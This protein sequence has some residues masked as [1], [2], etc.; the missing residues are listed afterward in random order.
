MS[1]GNVPRD[2]NLS[3][4][5]TL[6]ST[7]AK[8]INGLFSANIRTVGDLV[9]SERSPDVWVTAPDVTVPSTQLGNSYTLPGNIE[10]TQLSS[11]FDGTTLAVGLKNIVP[12][13]SVASI[14]TNTAVFYAQVPIPIPPD[15][16]GVTYGSVSLSDSGEIFAMGS[17]NDNA[18]VGAV[19]LFALIA[20][21]WTLQG[22]KIT[23]PGEIGAGNFG[24]QVSLSGNGTLLAVGSPNET[25]AGAAYIFNVQ[26]LANPVFVARIVGTPLSPNAVFGWDVT[27]SA[28]GST[29]AVGASSDLG[30]NGSVF[31]FTKVLGTWTQQAYLLTPAGPSTS[32]LGYNV[33]VSADGNIVTASSLVNAVIYYR[34]PGQALAASGLSGPWSVGSFLPL[35]YDLVSTSNQYF[36]SIS[37]D[38][39]TI[40]TSSRNN[41]ANVGASWIFTQGPL[42]TWIQNGPALV[43]SGAPVLATSQGYSIISGNGKVAVTQDNS[44]QKL[45]WVFV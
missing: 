18:S 28:D 32:F 15:A 3:S 37:Q 21:V 14:L 20:G 30:A 33:S 41:N 34:T 23:G 17:G 1:F 45:L 8:S 4:L 24:Q 39:N 42:G 22:T 5:A 7:A 38:G 16:V 12:G 44:D 27:F 26:Y 25:P 2:L 36:V 43:G 11:N 19:W 35:P 40:C 29:L 10:R 9:Q 6:R 31:V 13:N